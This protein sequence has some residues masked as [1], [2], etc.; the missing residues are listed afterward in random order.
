MKKLNNKGFAISTMLYGLLIIIVLLMSLIMSTMSFART[1]SKKFNDEIK[2]N[3]ES[4]IAYPPILMSHTVEIEN[5]K[6][7]I[8]IKGEQCKINVTIDVYGK[9]VGIDYSFNNG[10]IAQIKD[11]LGSTINF[12]MAYSLTTIK[13]SANVTTYQISIDLGSLNPSIDKEYNLY[14]FKKA[15]KDELGSS[16]SETT[17]KLTKYEDFTS[18]VINY[19]CNPDKNLDQ[20]GNIVVRCSVTKNKGSNFTED[21]INMENPSIILAGSTFN[22]SGFTKVYSYGLAPTKLNINYMICH[23]EDC[24]GNTNG[25]NISQSLPPYFS[26]NDIIMSIPKSSFFNTEVI[27]V[28]TPFK[29]C[30]PYPSSCPWLF[31]K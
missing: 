16:N 1:N 23:H 30:Y 8:C 31:I 6:S 28:N 19:E 3:L 13:Q 5:N 29:I 7:G 10:M 27:S 11:N 24:P 9:N 22:L 12:I 17:I 25:N 21:N 4:K 14:I 26:G 18:D 20:G 2:S 15:F